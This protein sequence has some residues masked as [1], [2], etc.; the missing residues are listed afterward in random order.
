MFWYPLAY[1]SGLESLEAAPQRPDS[2]AS[3]LPLAHS[4]IHMSVVSDPG[5]DGRLTWSKYAEHEARKE[6]SAIAIRKCDAHLA[7]FSRCAREQNL[8]VVFNCRAENRRMNDCLHRYTNETAFEE[9]KLRRGKELAGR[10][11]P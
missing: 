1:S 2:C 7:A 4:R 9:Y 8:L 10:E 5:R 6:L 3:A 11:R